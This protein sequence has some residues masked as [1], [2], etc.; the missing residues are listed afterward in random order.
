MQLVQTERPMGEKDSQVC[1]FGCLQRSRGRFT[2]PAENPTEIPGYGLG[3]SKLTTLAS[4][5]LGGSKSM[6]GMVNTAH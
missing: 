4:H 1:L 2:F 6:C 5:V 3:T